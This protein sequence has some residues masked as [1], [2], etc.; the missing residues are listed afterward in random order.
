MGDTG[1]P[2]FREGTKGGR[3][4]SR[5]GVGGTYLHDDGGVAPPD[6]GEEAVAAAHQRQVRPRVEVVAG[7]R[8]EAHG[9]RRVC[10]AGKMKIRAAW[11]WAN[12]RV[13]RS[14]QRKGGEGWPQGREGRGSPEAGVKIV[15]GG[16]LHRA[17]QG[18][19]GGEECA[20]GNVREICGGECAGIVRGLWPRASGR[21]ACIA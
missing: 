7:G 13:H 15:R 19:E 3:G 5:L 16:G 21:G 10:A 2:E 8:G 12:H 6:D 18:G 17:M 14:K 4:A 1:A 20:A 11:A 9:G